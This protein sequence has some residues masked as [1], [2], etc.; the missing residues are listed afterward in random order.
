MWRP[1]KDLEPFNRALVC[2][3]QE[4]LAV[5]RG[6][7]SLEDLAASTP[8]TDVCSH[9]DENPY[10]AVCMS[11]IKS[12][13]AMTPRHGINVLLISRAWVRIAHNLGERLEAFSLAALIHD[14]GHW[15][16]DDLVYVFGPFTHHEAKAMQ[17]HTD[18]AAI[19]DNADDDI[20]QWIKEH[21]EQPDGK[22]YPK[23]IKNPNPL[24]QLLRII[25]CFDGLTTPRRFR[26]THDYQDA[27][28]L[29]NRWAGYKFSKGLFKSFK[30]FMGMRPPGS[31]IRLQN[32]QAAVTLPNTASKTHVLVLTNE[33]GDVIKSPKEQFVTEEEI[34]GGAPKWQE[35]ALPDPWRALRPDLMGL[36]RFYALET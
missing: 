28:K 8:F 13:H 1:V 15:R 18:L 34:K 32:G 27:M 30:K 33:D 22:G 35:L 4:Y 20:I 9:I 11:R 3:E 17:K 25:D 36:P 2:L 12:G 23:G 7:N 14:L 26:L 5:L 31:I 21:H 29:M 24:S 6:K 19:L 16:P 10:Q